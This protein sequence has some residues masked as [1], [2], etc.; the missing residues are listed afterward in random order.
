M[1]LEGSTTFL[2]T[3]DVSQIGQMHILSWRSGVPQH[4]SRKRRNTGGSHQ[5]QGYPRMVPTSQCQGHMVLPWILQFLLKIH[6]FLFQHCLPP[7]GSY[8]TVKP[9]DLETWPK[10]CLLQSTNHVH[11]TTGSSLSWYPQ[12]LHSHDRCLANGIRSCTNVAQCQWRYATVQLSLP[13]I[14]PG[15]TK[16]WYLQSRI[17]CHDPQPQRIETIPPRISL[18]CGGSYRP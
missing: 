12:T 8:W 14:L 13:D 16:L 4:D 15:R 5:I 7:P 2:R 1:H 6:P 11:Q 18:P 3:R 9:L 17:A 10:A